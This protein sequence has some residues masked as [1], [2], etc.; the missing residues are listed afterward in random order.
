MMTNKELR[1]SAGRIKTACLAECRQPWNNRLRAENERLRAHVERIIEKYDAYRARGVISAG[2][3]YAEMVAAINDARMKFPACAPH[4]RKMQYGNVP[5]GLAYVFSVVFGVALLMLG[6]I[7]FIAW[8][9][10]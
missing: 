9:C 1:W 7:K 6:T 2:S 4:R 3:Q 5:G 10:Q 8:L